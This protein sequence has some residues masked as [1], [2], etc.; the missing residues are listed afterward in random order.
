MRR[1]FHINKD[2]ERVDL[3]DSRLKDFA[4]ANIGDSLDRMACISRSNIKPANKAKIF[5]SAYTVKVTNGDNLM[6]YYAIDNAKPGDVLVIDAEEGTTRAVYGEILATLSKK[7][8]LAGAIIDG[9]IRD[10]DAI[11]E[12]DFPVYYRG[13]SPNG[14]YKNGPGFINSPVNIAGITVSPGD[15]IIGDEDGIAVIK[16]EEVDMVIERVQE[17]ED[18]EEKL[19]DQISKNGEF[20]MS[21]LY[22]KLDSEDIKY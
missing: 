16:P 22:E 14:P 8:G 19:L 12:M 6:I 4:V 11:E 5:G 15:I 9:A 20:D 21:F 3:R 1:R 7:R 18:K 10:F 17:I 13:I 2:I